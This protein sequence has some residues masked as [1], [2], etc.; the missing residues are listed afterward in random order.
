MGVIYQF[1]NIASKDAIEK[2]KAF[3]E[4][5]E[6][7][8]AKAKTNAE[9]S[10]TTV[11]DDT[12]TS[13][14]TTESVNDTEV[15]TN[16]TTAI[17]TP[18]PGKGRIPKPKPSNWLQIKAKIIAKEITKIQALQELGIKSRITLNKWLAE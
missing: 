15:A 10:D 14:T 4:Q 5:E 16:T 11:A 7:I 2:K 18:R 9:S 17:V 1:G 6:A 8:K 13:E 12:V 3:D